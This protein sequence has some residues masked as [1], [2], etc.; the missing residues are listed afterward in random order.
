MQNAWL[1]LERGRNGLGADDVRVSLFTELFPLDAATPV[2]APHELS[3]TTF[4]D[5]EMTRD[6]IL[7]FIRDPAQLDSNLSI[8][9]DAQMTAGCGTSAASKSPQSSANSRIQF[10]DN[11]A[12]CGFSAIWTCR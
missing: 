6:V 8:A 7:Q 1:R 4:D 9:V 12:R 10:W 11:T 2:A 3:L 5:G